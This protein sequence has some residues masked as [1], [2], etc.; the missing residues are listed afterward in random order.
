MMFRKE[1]DELRYI[2]SGTTNAPFSVCVCVI[3]CFVNETKSWIER[4][5]LGIASQ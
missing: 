4:V 2:M 5:K 3:E 1:K